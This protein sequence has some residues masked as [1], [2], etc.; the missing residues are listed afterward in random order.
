[1]GL[2]GSGTNV[3]GKINHL[4]GLMWMR[5]FRRWSWGR[6]GHQHLAALWPSESEPPPEDAPVLVV[7]VESSDAKHL[8]DGLVVVHGDLQPGGRVILAVPGHTIWPHSKSRSELPP[9]AKPV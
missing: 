7:E 5:H 9:G 2:S 8:E 1:M 4:R 6:R 3:E